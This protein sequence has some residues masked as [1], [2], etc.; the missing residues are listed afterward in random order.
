[1]SMALEC[2]LLRSERVVDGP[3]G[4]DVAGKCKKRR[5]HETVG[6]PL[7]KFGAGNVKEMWLM[8]DTGSASGASLYA[9]K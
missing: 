2:S 9:S 6:G 4:V 5:W 7:P 8:H 3:R 1:M